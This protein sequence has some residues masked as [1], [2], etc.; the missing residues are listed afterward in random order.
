MIRILVPLLLLAPLPAAAAPAP[1]KAA[2]AAQPPRAPFASERIGVTVTGRGPDV[3]LIHGLNSSPQVWDTTVAAMPG[4]RY[5]LVHVAGMGGR[6]PGANAQGPVV[7]PVAEEIARYIKEAGL[8]KPAIVG[9]SLGGAWG[10]MVAARHPE[11]VGRLMVVDMLPF[12]GA[13]FGGPSATPESVRPIAEQFRQGML[14][15]TGPQRE[16]MAQQIIATMVRT[17]SLRPAAVA[18]ALGSDASVS[19]QAMYDLITTNLQPELR[20]IRVPMTVLWVRPPGAPV[21]EEQMVGFYK[22]AYANAPHAK[23]VRVP[24][25]YHFIMWDEPAA[26]QRELK[27]FLQGN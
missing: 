19:A 9:H 2:A 8:R 15:A 14:A 3:I 18:H 7:A 10:M 13:M 16:T 5:H 25:A 20:N 11:L 12:M 4:Y 6:A 27:A 1:A 26:F 17:E 23:I 22:G 21:T 24:N